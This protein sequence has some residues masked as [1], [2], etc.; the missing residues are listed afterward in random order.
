MKRTFFVIMLFA[1]FAAT[2]FASPAYAATGGTVYGT[3]SAINI[4]GTY[5]VTSSDGT[6]YTVTP[7]VGTDPATIVV[8]SLVQL[9]LTDNL[10]GTFTVTSVSF[11]DR[12]NGYYCSQ[13]SDL[14][15]AAEKFATQYEADYLYVQWMF[16]NDN[17]GLGVIKNILRASQQLGI[18]PALLQAA[19]LSGLGWGQIRQQYDVA[20]G[21][22][23]EAKANQTIK[24]TGKPANPGNG[25]GNG[26]GNGGNNGNGNGNN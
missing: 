18:D 5:S 8:G 13:S 4:D 1:L 23:T 11:N 12:I 10:D 22:S 17:M 24:T 7:P 14:Q 15:P 9:T 26:N 16:C 6:V 21:K 3:I 19:R 2:I 20:N 25:N